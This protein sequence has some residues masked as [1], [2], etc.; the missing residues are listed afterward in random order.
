MD[1]GSVE[2]EKSWSQTADVM[3]RQCG[4]IEKVGTRTTPVENDE[5]RK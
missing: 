2:L 3:N 5:H 4:T 1:T